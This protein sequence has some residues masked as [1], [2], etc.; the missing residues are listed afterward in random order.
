M[1][2]YY[3]IEVYMCYILEYT[4][5]QAGPILISLFVYECIYIYIY[6][7]LLIIIHLKCDF[8]LLCMCFIMYVL[9]CKNT[10]KSFY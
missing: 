9:Q 4:C 6:M 1:Y 10:I 2:L 3:F 7:P 8:P 5:W